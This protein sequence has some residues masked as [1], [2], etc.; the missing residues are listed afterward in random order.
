MSS[1]TWSLRAERQHVEGQIHHG[2]G[3]LRR[4]M[5]REPEQDRRLQEADVIH[6][7]FD[8]MPPVH[9]DLTLFV[10]ELTDR[11]IWLSL[12]QNDL[13]VEALHVDRHVP[14]VLS[15][16]DEYLAVAEVDVEVGARFVRDDD[17][18]TAE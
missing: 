5:V 12:L 15:E 16:I 8:R 2:V 11:V 4:C 17:L 10:V 18:E 13:V 3:T 6:V 9:I 14:S 7:Q 1:A